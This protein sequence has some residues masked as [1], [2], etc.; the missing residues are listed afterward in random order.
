MIAI[1]VELLHGTARAAS[2][3]DLALTDQGDPGE[4]PLSPAR[5]FSALVA[6]DGTRERCRMTGGSELVLLEAAG[7][8]TIYASPRSEVLASSVNPRY[9]V[10][11]A[12]AKGS[13]QEY[14]GRKSA[15]VRPGTRLSPRSPRITYVWEDV[16]GDP[17]VVAALAARAARVGYIGC[18]DSPARIRVHDELPLIEPAQ[19]WIPASD[20]ATELPV[21]FPGLTGVLDAMY[22]AFA[23]GQPARRS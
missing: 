5:V 13:V 6:G 21:P 18:A 3:S 10:V 4:W 15:P 2:A 1:S 20:G 14:P 22:D 17:D 7:P 8:P 11:P 16:Q 9:V 12:N 19:R 23:E